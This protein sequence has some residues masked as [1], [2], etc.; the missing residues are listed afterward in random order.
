MKAQTRL[1]VIVFHF[2]NAKEFLNAR[3]Q[4]YFDTEG[5]TVE[6]SPPYD[7]SRNGIA[8]RANGI[9][10]ERTRAALI[11]SGLPMN[12]LPYAAKYMARIHNLLSSSVLPG[13]ITSMEA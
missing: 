7:A 3:N 10:E 9:N 13:Q 5:I 6:T 11:Q 2:D 12:L 1:T 4:Q 8:E